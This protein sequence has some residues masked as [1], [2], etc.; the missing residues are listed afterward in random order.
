[1][2]TLCALGLGRGF[3]AQTCGQIGSKV[4]WV[5]CGYDQGPR[6]A[7][8]ARERMSL[9][10]AIAVVRVVDVLDMAK[11]TRYERVHQTA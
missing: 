9:E 5:A 7:A 2:V 11:L 10:T 1:M 8:A 4:G 6:V 3:E